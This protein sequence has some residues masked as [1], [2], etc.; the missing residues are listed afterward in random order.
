[1]AT[2]IALTVRDNSLAALAAVVA[3]FD[4]SILV[5][6]AGYCNFLSQSGMMFWILNAAL[7]AACANAER[8]P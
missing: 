6:T 3:A 1:V 7:Y 4:L 5:N 2:R 8:R